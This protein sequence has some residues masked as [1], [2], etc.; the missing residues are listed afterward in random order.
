MEINATQTRIVSAAKQLFRQKGYFS[1]RVSDI[2]KALNISKGNLTYYFP[3]KNSL[4]NHL[5]TDYY[6]AIN[7]Y[8]DNAGLPIEHFYSRELYSSLIADANILLDP[9]IRNFYNELIN[10]P[11]QWE[12]TQRIC[13]TQIRLLHSNHTVVATPQELEYYAEGMVGAYN[14]IDKMFISWQKFSLDD[15]YSHIILKQMARAQLWTVQREDTSLQETK[16][17][18]RRHAKELRHRNFSHIRLL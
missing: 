7:K 10:E 3:T 12:I 5:F 16:N 6:E 11:I 8:I 15:V 1:T 18:I 9:Q 13:L 17:S 2:S 4:I 14:A